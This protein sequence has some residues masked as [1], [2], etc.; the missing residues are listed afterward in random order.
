[1]VRIEVASEDLSRAKLIL[2]QDEQRAAETATW[3]CGKCGEENE[4]TFDLCWRCNS[5]PE[6]VVEDTPPQQ[7]DA[8]PAPVTIDESTL[9]IPP[10]DGNPYRPVLVAPGR[11]VPPVAG[12]I[13][14]AVD[15]ATDPELRSDIRRAL[16]AAVFGSFVFPPL[17]NLY[18]MYRLMLLS[19]KFPKKTSWRMQVLAAWCINL[20]TIAVW[21]LIWSQQFLV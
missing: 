3:I 21:S 10:N 17:L 8:A 12:S 1:M 16:L 14:A 19:T 4:A 13:T 18:S 9:P 6:F 5:P 2:E 15:S 20:V 7:V 11:V